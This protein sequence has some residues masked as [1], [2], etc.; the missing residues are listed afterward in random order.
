MGFGASS[1]LF[2]RM[3][4]Q[5]PQPILHF[6]LKTN[7]PPEKFT[8]ANPIAGIWGASRNRSTTQFEEIRTMIGSRCVLGIALGLC[9]FMISTASHAVGVG[10]RCGGYVGIP[11]DKG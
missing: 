3:P 2:G 7:Q 10:A 11:C 1:A 5:A 6:R 9:V 8:I 4:C